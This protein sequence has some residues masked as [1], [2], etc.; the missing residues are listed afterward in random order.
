MYFITLCAYIFVFYNKILSR[1]TFVVIFSCINMKYLLL[2][3][4]ETQKGSKN[5]SSSEVQVY[6][7][8]EWLLYHDNDVFVLN[9]R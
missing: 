6:N 1:K 7:S 3:L 5:Y 8:N 4:I 2:K 9:F